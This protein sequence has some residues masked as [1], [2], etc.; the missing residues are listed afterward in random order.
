MASEQFHLSDNPKS[1]LYQIR[2]SYLN[3]EKDI[4]YE[5]LDS[6]IHQGEINAVIGS[7]IFCSEIR[8]GIKKSNPFCSDPLSYVIKSDLNEH[9][10]LIYFDKSLK[11][12]HLCQ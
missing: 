3:D 4:F 8:H 7:L 5:K 9:Y 6:L 12:F 2:C 11:N 1:K 10:D